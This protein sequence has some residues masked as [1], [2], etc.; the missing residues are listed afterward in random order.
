[1]SYTG[2]RRS[3]SIW[4]P[5]IISVPAVVYAFFPILLFY[6]SVVVVVVVVVV[7]FFA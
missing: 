3:V 5:S 2:N 4:T 7:V 1:L 6:R